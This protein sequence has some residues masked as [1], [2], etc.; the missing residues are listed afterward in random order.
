MRNLHQDASPVARLVARFGSSVLH[1]FQHLQGIIDE[2]VALASVNV[3]HHADTTSV[4]L[5]VGTVQTI[6]PV[7][8]HNN[9]VI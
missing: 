1:V 7:L 8:C 5:V 9:R 3:H 2:F 4:V 6:I